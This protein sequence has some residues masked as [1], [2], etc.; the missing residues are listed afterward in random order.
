MKTYKE[1]LEEDKNKFDN[2][3]DNFKKY[4]EKEDSDEDSEDSEDKVELGG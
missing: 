3:G 1:L 4:R 2:L